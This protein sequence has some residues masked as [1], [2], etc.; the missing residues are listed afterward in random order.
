VRRPR[1]Q[2]CIKRSL[3]AALSYDFLLPD[4]GDDMAK[5]QK[6]L[7]KSFEWLWYE[8]LEAQLQSA[9]EPMRT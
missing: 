2:E 4:V 9:K 3:D 1:T 5:I 7:Q 8:D 6:R